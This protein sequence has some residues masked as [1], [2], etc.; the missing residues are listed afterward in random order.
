MRNQITANDLNV[1]NNQRV[2]TFINF[3]KKS[4]DYKG[5]NSIS[6]ILLNEGGDNFL[7]YIEGRGLANDPDIIVLSSQHHYYYDTEELKNIKT[8]IN[9]KELNQIKEVKSFLQTMFHLLPQN[10]NFV[11]CFVDNRMLNVFEPRNNFLFAKQKSSYDDLEETG[12]V[13]NIPFFNMILNFMDSRT[14]KYMSARSVSE[15]LEENR[16]RVLSLKEI[17]G[18]T[19][20]HAQKPDL[21]MNKVNFIRCLYNHLI[22]III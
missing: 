10:S 2:N 7:K 21:R 15:M 8:V 9:L 17:N 20:F 13:S 12:I 3:D 5:N 16:F 18:L 6:E 11:G 14:N 1:V 22:L 19:Y 4:E